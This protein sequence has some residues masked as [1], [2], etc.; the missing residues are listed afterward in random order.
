MWAVSIWKFLSCSQKEVGLK[1]QSNFKA[2][3]LRSAP[4]VGRGLLCALNRRAFSVHRGLGG[5][6]V[7]QAEEQLVIRNEG[8]WYS[9]LAVA[10]LCFQDSGDLPPWGA[11]ARKDPHLVSCI[12]C[13]GVSPP[14]LKLLRW[15]LSGT[16]ALATF[17]WG[18]ASVIA[19]TFLSSLPT[20]LR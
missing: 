5:A 8:L 20:L 10:C 4:S 17:P 9:V 2:L 15:L 16:M 3:C 13:L 6:E 18:L 14:I 7:D 1:S 19:V 11:L 12:L